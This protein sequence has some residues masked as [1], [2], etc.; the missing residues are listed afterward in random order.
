M[1]AKY[2]FQRKFF[3]SHNNYFCFK[4]GLAIAIEQALNIIS[5]KMRQ[6]KKKILKG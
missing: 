6:E 3:F 5:D 2:A 1:H 4:K